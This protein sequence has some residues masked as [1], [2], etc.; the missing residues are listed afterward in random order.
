MLQRRAKEQE[1]DKY[2]NLAGIKDFE[3]DFEGCIRDQVEMVMQDYLTYDEI[4]PE[5]ELEDVIMKAEVQRMMPDEAIPTIAIFFDKSGSC[6]RAI[7]TLNNAI[8]TVKKKYVD[9]GMCKLDLYYFGDRVAYNDANA[10]VGSTTEAWPHI[11]DTIKKGDYNNVIVM[12]DADIG[13]QNNNGES[14]IVTGCVWWLWVNG[15]RAPK[16]VKELRGMQHNF[17]GEI[18]SR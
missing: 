10:Y 8:A 18:R 6:F 17:E 9:T 13:E 2:N 7:P 14:Y 1:L 4:N 3:L 16:C 15:K 11:I 12:S 5:Y